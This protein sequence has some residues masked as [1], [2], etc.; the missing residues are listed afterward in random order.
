[1]RGIA[2][3]EA[4]A[5][6]VGHIPAFA[7][8]ALGD[9]AAG[10]INA[11]RVK[12]DELHVLQR[13]SG[14]QHHRIAVAGAG[15]GRSAGEISTAIAAGGEDDDVGAEAMKRAVFKV[16]RHDPPASALL[17]GD[18]VQDKIFDEKLSIVL[19][20]LL[21]ERVDQRVSGAVGRGAGAPGRIAVAVIHHVSAKRPL[22]DLTVLGP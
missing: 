2:L 22:V 6:A 11:G 1:M 17:V 18:Q 10:A 7:A 3:H 12:L 4:L 15:M 8:R 14:P 9:Q 13:Q 20:A 16:P 19:Q 5:L 21:I